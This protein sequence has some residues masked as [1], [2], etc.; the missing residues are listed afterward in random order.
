MYIF[1]K[2]LEQRGEAAMSKTY[3]KEL[4]GVFGYPV[5]ENPTV[6]LEEAAFQKLNL[7]YQY[8]TIEVRPEDLRD[9]MRSVTALNMRGINL[10]IPHKCEV[11]QYLDSIS[12]EAEIIGA[13]NV[14]INEK[15]KLHGDNTDGKGFLKSLTDEGLSP[16]GKNIVILGAGGAARAIAVELALAGAGH[17]TII[18]RSIQR[19]QELTDLIRERTNADACYLP[20]TRD[21]SIPENTNILINATSIGLY[22]NVNEKPDINYD[23]VTGSMLVCDVIPNHPHTLF[24]KEAEKK[25]AKTIHGLNMIVNQGAINFT[26]WTGKDA[27]ID[28]MTKAMSEEFRL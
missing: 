9:A 21:I 10:T 5:D 13:V 22:P 28:V 24:L 4:V 17:I 16:S 2:T 1:P 14:V 11:I 8:L 6:V 18:N 15:G 7:N 19:G 26:L 20:W 3:R 12:Q 23:S 27:P 25:G